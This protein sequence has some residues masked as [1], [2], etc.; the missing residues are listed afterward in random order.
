MKFK[1]NSKVMNKIFLLIILI[2]SLILPIAYI[3]PSN[4]L[5]VDISSGLNT[6]QANGSSED[7]VIWKLGKG[8][9]GTGA[10]MKPRLV[11]FTDGN[12]SL[13]IVGT[14]E[15][16]A[17]ITLEGVINMSYKTFGSVIDFDIIEDI[18]GDS[19]DDIIL[20][21][22]Y[23][24]HPNLIAI[25]SNN[26]TEL[27]KFKPTIEGIN[28]ETF[29]TQKFITYTW[30]VEA[31]NDINDDSISEIVISSWYRIFVISGKSG[32]KIWMR[33]GDFTND[34]WKLAVLEDINNNGFETII[35][36][37]EEGKL[38]AFDSRSGKKLWTFKVDDLIFRVRTFSG[39]STEIV[40]NSIDDIK[41]IEDV[42]NDEIN[43]ILI[44]ADDGY[45]RLI[46]GNSGIE[47]DNIICYNITKPSESSSDLEDSPYTSRE[48]LF[49]KTGIKI[50]EIPDIDNNGRS[51]YI[52]IA[53]DLDYGYIYSNEKKIVG[54][55]FHI[56]PEFEFEK[57]NITHNINWTFQNFYQD[58]YPEI[59]KFNSGIQVYFYHYGIDQFYWEYTNPQIIRYDIN[60]RNS[61]NPTVVYIDPDQP[62][63]SHNY[64]STTAPYLL[65]I[66]DVNS[67]GIDD[68]FAIST[69]GRYLCID[70]ANDNTLWVRSQKNFELEVVEIDDLND[71]GFEDFLIKQISNFEP[72]WIYL[73]D[74]EGEESDT[75]KPKIISELFTID[76]KTGNVIWSFQ[77]SSPQYYEGLR[78][79][80]NVGDITDDGIDDYVGWLIPSTIPPDISEIIEDLIGEEPIGQDELSSSYE[81]IYR[82]LLSKYTK[83]L[84]IN[85][86]NG[87]TF[88]DTQL[89]DFPYKF[90]RQFNYNGTYIEPT[91]VY[92]YG[93][94]Y[95]NRINGE[96][97]EYWGSNGYI[98]WDNYDGW[99]ISTLLHPSDIKINNGTEFGNVFDL[100]GE[101][102]QNYTITCYNSSDSSES[103]KVGT[104]SDS[105][106]IGTVERED[107]SYWILDSI[108][109][110]E[111]QQ[112]KAE[113]SFKMPQFIDSELKYIK[114]DYTG[115]VLNDF[116][117]QIEISIYNFSSHK[118]KKISTGTINDTELSNYEWALDSLDG[119]TSGLENLVK[120][121]L[122]ARN[123]SAF[124]IYMDELLVNYIYRFDNYTISAE[125]IGGSWRTLFDLT[126]PLDFSDNKSLGVMD[127]Q[128]S[129]IER[130][131][132][133]K[134]QNRIKVNTNDTRWY[135]FTY[136]IYDALNEKW[137]L[138]NWSD[139]TT[140]NNHTYS[141]LKGDF[142]G[143]RNNYTSFTFGD[144]YEYDS[145]WLI[146]RGTYDA[147][148]YIEFDYENKTTLS[149][150]IDSD[151]YF[152]LR[153]NVTNDNFPFNITIDNFGI[154][155]FYWGLFSS[156]YDRYYLWDYDVEYEEI[157]FS[158]T[159][160]LNLEIQDFDVVNGTNDEYLDVIAI[161]GI[162][163][164]SS[165]PENDL[166]TRICLFDI[167]NQ[168]SYTKWSLNK[169]YIPFQNVR[170]LP[171]NNSLNNWILSGIFQY[172]NNY[173]CSHRLI[174]DPHWKS[175]I[176]HFENYNVSKVV[177]NYIWDEIPQF[178]SE[179]YY[180]NYPYEFP[181]K[182]YVTKDGKVGLILGIYEF[183]ESDFDWGSKLTDIRIIDVRNRNILS[184]I[185]TTQLKYYGT[186]DAGELDFNLEGA[187]LGLLISYEDFNDDDFLDHVGFYEPAITEI[188]YMSGIQLRIY[189]GS[190]SDSDPVI[191]SSKSF[192]DVSFNSEALKE[193]MYPFSL[194]DDIN[195]DNF[196]DAI[197]GIQT[198]SSSYYYYDEGTISYSYG[199]CKGSYIEVYDIHNS[200]GNEI[201][202]LTE[203]KWVLDSS[204]CSS[205]WESPYYEFIFNVERIGDINGDNSTEIQ[206]YRN[207]YIKSSGGYLIR[208]IT[209]ILDIKNQN[210]LYRFNMEVDSI[211][212]I[213]DLN[214]DGKDELLISSEE[215]VYCINSKFGVQISTPKDK[216]NMKSH[217]FDIKWD[218]DS[219][220]DYFEVFIDGVSQG[221]TEA[222][223]IFVSLGSG[224][225][226]IS[227]VMYDATGLILSVNNIDVLVPPNEIH[228]ILTFV[229]LIVIAGSYI[230]YRRYHKK[231][232][233]LVLIDKRIKK[234]GN[235]R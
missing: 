58:S 176:T 115:F 123:T 151:K 158:K 90:Y 193:G 73:V 207:S 108:N 210:I 208:P 55:I 122:E 109:S 45:L 171:I 101:Q 89:I 170:I 156:Q 168:E 85:G 182:T 102:G 86:F 95:Y 206:V 88:W 3:F 183:I 7:S 125:N 41:I 59:I 180:N 142:G 5:N 139:S 120:I 47:L 140:W 216:Q 77:T 148:P 134:L 234:G 165:T 13:I 10:T 127:Y 56:N 124:T 71:D 69:D 162:E 166:S 214:G 112:I 107:G 188:N 233:D 195:N 79:L 30:D 2:C 114:V 197:I 118:W 143:S 189:S 204:R 199:N 119:L 103:L 38:C 93:N 177:I 72:D 22:Y 54:T 200:I 157:K 113:L 31:I 76:G 147:D 198:V 224:W 37:S 203:Y 145:L 51:N 61:E 178:P 63:D 6:T 126:I 164:T 53:T 226:Q 99:D 36:G 65:N 138:C 149:N 104:T 11:N 129:Q 74:S 92:N 23:N 229:F 67:D 152:R 192:G 25:A 150:F 83:L 32:E 29:E 232:A 81:Y 181:G 66:G 128:L 105:S 167:K 42:D 60:D 40:P 9:P 230:V 110:N 68:L 8:L 223:K 172:G 39:F 209:E 215:I 34:I 187:G 220:Y 19:I 163:G 26:G 173:N 98:N 96:M 194:I 48:R 15:G 18:S 231:K 50:Y 44:A 80:K 141:D 75:E 184:M 33:D 219:Y 131:S 130:F 135:N 111:E 14:D 35:A 16:L 159:N 179:G 201:N 235:K 70:T 218:T 62:S 46:S 153:V 49:T 155:A 52:S 57:F 191:L 24:D 4:N 28:T 169:T 227:I 84:A 21:A 217:D 64:E 154:G 202:E 205:R 228:L 144:S 136:E 78:D 27:W 211:H 97:S 174:S 1:N 91:E 186:P 196:P 212:K 116:I 213:A 185:S 161:I 20:I 222:K 100:W 225:R 82:T 132:A 87:T 175:Q 160:L 17:A 133:F 117:D 94:N 121:K 106:S 12:E 221:P 43:D 190:S 137:V 146:T